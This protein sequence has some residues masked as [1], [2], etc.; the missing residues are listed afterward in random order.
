[1]LK[2]RVSLQEFFLFFPFPVSSDI[3]Q[4]FKFLLCPCP[5][6]CI[7]NKSGFSS[8]SNTNMLLIN[9]YFSIN[10]LIMLSI[11]KHKAKYPT[12]SFVFNH[13]K[14]LPSVKSFIIWKWL[15]MIHLMY[16]TGFII[17]LSLCITDVSIFTRQR[18][19]TWTDVSSG[20]QS[21]WKDTFHMTDH[22]YVGCHLIRTSFE[23]YP[24][25]EE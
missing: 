5:I 23:V 15:M 19:V 21:A 11:L 12:A 10:I 20:N 25:G 1:M 17:P 24:C 3:S 16:A 9:R 14:M 2:N 18:Q 13:W 7:Q 6:D 22:D 8:S 4:P